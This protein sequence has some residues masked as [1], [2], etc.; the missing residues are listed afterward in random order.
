MRKKSANIVFNVGVIFWF[1]V[2]RGLNCWD[3]INQGSRKQNGTEFLYY[4]SECSGDWTRV[5]E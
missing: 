3:V 2:P 5:E 1:F 4:C